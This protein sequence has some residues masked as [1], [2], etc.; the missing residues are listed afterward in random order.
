[1]YKLHYDNFLI[2]EHDDDDGTETLEWC[3]Y[4][5]VKK[6]RRYVCSFW[7]DPRTWRTDRHCMTLLASHR[8]VKIWRNT[9][10]NVQRK[11]DHD[12][13]FARWLHHAMWHVALESWQWIHQVAAPCNVIRGSGMTCANVRHVG[14]LHLVSISTTS[15]QLTC[16]YIQCVVAMASATVWRFIQIGPPSAQKNDVMSIFKMADLSY[17]RF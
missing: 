9:I 16:H 6:F 2:N 11:H 4:P 12:I 8:A 13:D 17:L 3:R 15:P 10:F 1:M 7:R 14:I 5:M